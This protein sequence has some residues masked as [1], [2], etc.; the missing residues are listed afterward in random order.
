MR[1]EQPGVRPDAVD[2]DAVELLGGGD[3]HVR[4]R[5]RR[6]VDDQIVD[7]VTGCALDDV[8]RQDVGPHRPQRHGKGAEA[9]WS[10]LK[11]DP[12]EIRRHAQHCFT[13]GRSAATREMVVGGPDALRRS[14]RSAA[15]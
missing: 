1:L 5:A 9:A 8:E 10:V 15:D 2:V 7:G 6:Q 3:Q 4:H 14:R 12:Q 11:L 13:E